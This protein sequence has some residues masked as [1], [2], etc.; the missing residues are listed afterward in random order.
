MKLEIHGALNI[1]TKNAMHLGLDN[2]D[3]V[4]LQIISIMVIAKP[5]T[6]IKVAMTCLGISIVHWSNA[7][8][9]IDSKPPDM[10][11]NYITK[12]QTLSIHLIVTYTHKHPNLKDLPFKTY[13]KKYKL[14]EGAIYFKPEDICWSQLYQKLLVQK[15]K[16]CH[17]HWLYPLSDVDSFFYIMNYCNTFLS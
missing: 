17:I 6:S 2:L 12:S 3:L 5:I 13:F 16:V 15:H 8:I 14:F 10:R 7:V 11:T 9:Y 1:D 4:Q